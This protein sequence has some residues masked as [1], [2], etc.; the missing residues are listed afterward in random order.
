MQT[1]V[2]LFT[3][4]ITLPPVGY[5]HQADAALRA[6]HELSVSMVAENPA[7]WLTSALTAWTRCT[8]LGS[9]TSRRELESIR[10]RLLRASVALRRAAREDHRPEGERVMA[11][12]AARRV[13]AAAALVR[14]LAERRAA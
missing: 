11:T 7:V 10:G 9:G 3:P 2:I 6:A 1:N 4:P 13:E 14:T 8:A 12:A 5:V